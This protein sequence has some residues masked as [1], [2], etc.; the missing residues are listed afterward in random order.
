MALLSYNGKD[1]LE[2]FLPE[3]LASQYPEF[4]VVVIDNGSTDG[5][6]A[7]VKT[8]YPDLKI[9]RHSVNIGF[10]PGYTEALKL[11]EATY[12]VLLSDDVTVSPGW[13]A[14]V[15]ELM[16]NDPSIAAVQ[17]KILSYHHRENFEYAGA[18][19]AFIDRYGYPLC[20]GRIFN[21]LEKD[22]GQYD[23]T[24]EVFWASGA[25]IFLRSSAYHDVGGFD[26]DF[27]AHF[28]E[29]DLCWRLKNAGYKVM[30]CPQSVVFHIGGTVI[31][32]GSPDKLFLN[33]RNSLATLAK[34]LD[35]GKL[36]PYL[37]IRTALDWVAL[38]RFLISLDFGS[39]GAI[40]RAHFS[41]FL[42]FGA[43]VRKR[44]SNKRSIPNNQLSGIYPGSVVWSYFIKGRKKFS[45]LAFHKT[46]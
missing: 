14:P 11:M 36:Y 38:A 34:N 19:G 45:E 12:F 40:I 7:F 10:T 18:A 6:T 30:V 35:T 5:S 9:V 41:F 1:L 21:T 31:Q 33:I 39:V 28:E 42:N 2:K 13:L 17:P 4:E 43:W 37:T 16:D 15:I 26:P 22:L 44:R 8:H 46:S 25:A 27:Y 32:Y 3:I 29:I 23:D 24:A 20:R